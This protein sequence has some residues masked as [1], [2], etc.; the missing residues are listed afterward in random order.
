MLA[1]GPSSGPAE[2]PPSPPLILTKDRAAPLS[3]QFLGKVSLESLRV[4]SFP[5][6]EN[7]QSSWD[8]LWD[9][10]VQ[11]GVRDIL[12]VVSICMDKMEHE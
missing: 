6:L 11:F 3:C 10:H 5:S 9:C 4:L 8:L 12:S 7:W 1:V 2:P